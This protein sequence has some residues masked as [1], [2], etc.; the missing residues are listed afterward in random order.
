MTPPTINQNLKRMARDSAI[1]LPSMVVPGIVG[2]LLLRVLTT[3]FTP[4]QYG[5]YNLALST[6]GLIKVFSLIW[7]SSSAMRYYHRY[8]KKHAEHFFISTLLAAT[9]ASGLFFALVSY[10][11]LTFIFQGRISNEFH[12]VLVITILAS[13]FVTFFEIFVVIFRAGLNPSRYSLYWLIYV[14]GKPLLGIFLVAKFK[15]GV[16]GIYW[17]FLIVPL[18]LDIIMLIDQQTLV[19]FRPK[20]CSFMLVKRFAS[21]GVPLALSNAAFWV[22]SL[23]D[24]YLIEYFRGSSEVGLYGLGFGI[25]EKTLQFAY[26]TLMLAAF[27]I[28]IQNWESSRSGETQ[29]LI[30]EMSRYYLLFITPILVALTVLPRDILLFFSDKAFISSARVIPI[31]ACGLYIYGLAQYVQKGLEL[32]SNSKFIA[33]IAGISG[34]LNIVLN[35][36]LIPRIGYLGAAVS[37]LFA[38]VVYFLCSLFFVRNELPWKAPWPSVLN[39]LFAAVGMGLSIILI[40]QA[41]HIYLLQLLLSLIGGSLVY[42]IVLAATKEIRPNELAIIFGLLKRNK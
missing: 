23:S 9:L 15:M 7:L 2:I 10:L 4:E 11:L 13:V 25:P 28:I 14:I 41:T 38:Y 34:L 39:A 3:L 31:I 33:V 29:Q 37:S 17:G 36:I 42:I 16:E 32:K 6:I 21:Y 24:R 30:T 1:Y 27:P 35:I 20:F 19:N 18:I 5:C 26:M 40:H 8:L 12:S 22:L